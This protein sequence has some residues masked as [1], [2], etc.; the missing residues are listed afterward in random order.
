[1][2]RRLTRL[3]AVTALLAAWAPPARAQF[4]VFDPSNYAEAILQVQQLIR[5][6]LFL[7]EQAQRVPVDIATRY[8]AHSLDWTY[9]DLSNGALYAQQILRALNEGDLSG[10]AYRQVTDPLDTPTDIIGYLPPSLLRR[11]TDSYAAIE[12]QDSMTRLAVDQTG[13]AR[14]DGPFTLQA[15]RNV[16][17]DIANTGDAFHSQTALLEKINA[18]FAIDLRLDE[19]TNQFQLT[20]LEQILVDNTR[21]R[22]AEAQLMNATIYQWRFGSTYGQDLFRNT[23]AHVDG[24]RPF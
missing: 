12:V 16:E 6:Y 20:T 19:Q 7:I 4:V 13:T 1:M 2:T 22:D 23:A 18:A 17:H 15:V 10:A 8:H 14:T 21:K 3:L 5:Q 9:H 11:L 24:W